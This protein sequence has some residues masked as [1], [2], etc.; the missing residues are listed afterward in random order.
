MAAALLTVALLSEGCGTETSEVASASSVQ[1]T[2]QPQ[3]GDARL[4][5]IAMSTATRFGED[6]PTNVQAV[7]T[8]RARVVELV[9]SGIPDDTPVYLIQAQGT[10]ANDRH[11]RPVNVSVPPPATGAL[12]TVVDAHS[13]D[14]L[15]VGTGQPVDLSTLG[16]VH[17]LHG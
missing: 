2:P 5:E 3:V 6:H 9:G 13:G 11:S 1:E 7:H 15:D 4:Y 8:T 10:F 12:M 14:T 17:A 16:A